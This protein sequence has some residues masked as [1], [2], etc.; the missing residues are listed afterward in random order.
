VVV[1]SAD[2]APPGSRETVDTLVDKLILKGAKVYYYEIQENLHVSG[3]GSAGDIR[4]L[5]NLIKPRYFI[6][7]GG[8]PRHIR[9]YSFL[10]EETGVN[11]KQIFELF[12]HEILQFSQNQARVSGKI[13][14]RKILVKTKRD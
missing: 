6:P 7:I 12:D 5:M 1:F 13:K 2:P 8:D 11:R 14:A 4:L 9:A 3:H 10:A